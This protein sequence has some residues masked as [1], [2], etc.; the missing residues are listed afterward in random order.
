MPANQL[1]GLRARHALL[2][3]PDDL[4]FRESRRAL[5]NPPRRPRGVRGPPTYCWTLGRGHR[6]EVL[7]SGRELRWP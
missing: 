3:D 2:Q 1:A 4:L 5:S 7:P 6:E